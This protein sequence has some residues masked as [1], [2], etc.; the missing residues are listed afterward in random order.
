MATR[1]AV[2]SLGLEIRGG[3]HT[4][5]VEVQDDHVTG[6]AVHI[7]A[8]M[9][10]LAGPGEIVASA[11][12]K[13]LVVGSGLRFADRGTHRLKGVPGRWRAFAVVG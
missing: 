6:M 8:R 10:A 9:I 5:E 3:V 11:T 1:D 13:D 4:G 2:W 7:G 12:V